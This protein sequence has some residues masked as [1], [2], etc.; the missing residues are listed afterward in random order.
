[1]FG[2]IQE[3]TAKENSPFC[4]PYW[5]H[6]EGELGKEGL[7]IVVE[8]EE[9]GEGLRRLENFDENCY[10]LPSVSTISR[11]R[12]SYCRGLSSSPPSPEVHQ[13]LP[14]PLRVVPGRR[15]TGSRSC[16]QL[17]WSSLRR[18]S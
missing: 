4:K 7:R 14:R 10:V 6:S 1:M 8:E 18:E 16:L 12:R 13:T 3:S 17:I 9:E 11:Y 2:Q 5:R 15:C